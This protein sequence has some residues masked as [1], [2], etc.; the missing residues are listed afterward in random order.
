MKHLNCTSLAAE[1][2]NYRSL[3]RFKEIKKTL[4]EQRY[5]KL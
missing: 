4:Q 3:V 5:L 2:K 1:L